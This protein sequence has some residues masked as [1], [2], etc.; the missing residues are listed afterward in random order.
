MKER[1]RS[2][3]A[4][5]AVG[6]ALLAAAGPMT[7]CG[8]GTAGK[9]AKET[10][11]DPAVVAPAQQLGK[12]Y[13]MVAARVRPAVVSVY[14]EK[15]VK[16]RQPEFDLPFGDDLFRQFFGEAAPDRP[17]P[18]RPQQREY[19]VPQRGMGSGMILDKKGHILTNNHVVNDVDEVK[20]Q[21]ADRRTFAAE[22]VSADPPS[23]LA[24]IRIKGHVPDDLPTVELGNSDE[25]EV[26]DLVMAVGA[27]FGF[28]QT[29]TT[30]IISAKG[31]SGVGINAYEDFLQTDAAI[32]PGN[33]GGPLVDMRGQVIGVNSAI[34][35]S[36]GQSAGVGFAIPIN[37][38]KS[39]L[40]TLMKGEKVSRGLLGIVIQEVTSEL[41]KHFGLS[42]TKGA[43]VAQVNKDSAAEKAGLKTG[44]VIVRYD[45][46]EVQDTA[47]LRNMV[48]TTK[49]G[50]QVKV[51]II[52]GGKEETH[53]VTVGKLTAEEAAAGGPA[54]EGGGNAVAKFG[55]SVQTLTPDLAKQFG[56]EDEKGAIISDVDEGTPASSAGLQQGDLVAEVN[57]Q[58]I[59]SA[60]DVQKALAKAKDAETV[61]LLIKRKGASLFVLLRMK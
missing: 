8:A 26:G 15:M 24:V 18:G 35:T 53:D 43:L 32:N 4:G 28:A 51:V 49:P 55:F 50:S 7:S 41:A 33:S 16:L 38:V 44:D 45:G 34:A 6:I 10:P 30:G 37:M 58:K 36:I 29:V 25:M 27:P 48:A 60:D 22:I 11:F 40:P 46:H 52:R 42:D 2:G 47:H 61:L 12:A 19:R 57:R 5:I 39:V 13:A 3:L 59:T 1:T 21:L 31:R 56:Y 20:V 23:D 54:E 9:P 14:S 17:R